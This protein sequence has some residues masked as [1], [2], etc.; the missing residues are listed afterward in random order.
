MVWGVWPCMLLYWG[1]IIARSFLGKLYRQRD[2][3]L[4]DVILGTVLYAGM[5]LYVCCIP[6]VQLE[7]TLTYLLSAQFLCLPSNMMSGSHS[8]PSLTRPGS[9]L[10]ITWARPCSSQCSIPRLGL[11]SW[12]MLLSHSNNSM[13]RER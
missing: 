4:A 5:A 10:P 12:S 13:L 3:M 1:W 9:A 6:T 11:N 7:I 2:I 8:F